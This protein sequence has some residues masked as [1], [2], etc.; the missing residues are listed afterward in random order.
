MPASPSVRERKDRRAVLARQLYIAV[1]NFSKASATCPVVNVSAI[2]NV[3][4]KGKARVAPDTFKDDLPQQSRVCPIQE[5]KK[6]LETDYLEATWSASGID[7]FGEADKP[8][9]TIHA[10]IGQSSASA[11]RL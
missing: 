9:A 6:I 8:C 3:G 11:T 1:V 4:V 7:R 5:L 2:E 10:E